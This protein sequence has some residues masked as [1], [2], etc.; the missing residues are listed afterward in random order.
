MTELGSCGQDESGFKYYWKVLFQACPSCLKPIIK[1]K[2]EECVEGAWVTDEFMAFPK[3]GVRTPAPLEVPA[4][5]AADYNE[6]GL[7]LE[8]SAQASAALSRRCL[9]H[10]LE[11]SGLS[12]NKNL[13]K[14][15]E[16]AMGKSL[17][18]HITKSLDSI[19]VIGNIAAH[20][21]KSV[22]TGEII[23]V[24]PHEAEWNLEVLDMLFDF[25]YVQ[26]AKN[27]ARRAALDAKLAEA[28]KPPLK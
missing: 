4:A 17:P 25:C 12:K 24:E 27:A 13:N 16:E 6:A 5:I 11:N 18:S 15:I 26:P 28:G 23:S 8:L 14:A 20:T 7:V 22:N 21:Q 9:Q 1:L 3:R 2:K 10:L 19:R